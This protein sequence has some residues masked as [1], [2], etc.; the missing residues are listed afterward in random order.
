[1]EAERVAVHRRFDEAELLTVREAAPERVTPPCAHYGECGGC[2]LQHLALG[3]QRAHK[4][5]VLTEALRRAKID[6]LPTVT[7]PDGNLPGPGLSAAG[8]LLCALGARGRL[9]L[10]FR[11]G[12]RS[13][14]RWP[15]TVFN[16]GSGAC[17][18]AR[19]AS[20][21]PGRIGP[22]PLAHPCG[23]GGGRGGHRRLEPPRFSWAPG[24]ARTAFRG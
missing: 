22:R 5:A 17:R 10:G 11:E 13:S 2:D 16:F 24:R 12:K 23:C 19:A 18:G 7:G 1:M 4:V 15:P 21:R 20:G 9:T 8:A 3:A 14:H 6:P